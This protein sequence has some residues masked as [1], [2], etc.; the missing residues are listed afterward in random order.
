MY[1]SSD[2]YLALY[3]IEEDLAKRLSKVIL[4]F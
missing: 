3:I 1:I 4:S 2:N